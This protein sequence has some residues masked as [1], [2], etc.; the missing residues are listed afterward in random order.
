[1][2]HPLPTTPA[3]YLAQSPVITQIITCL[4][5][6]T[7][8]T[9]QIYLAP[10]A[11]WCNADYI[12][13]SVQQII[14]NE[15]RVILA[16]GSSVEYDILALNLGSRTR[17]TVGKD[18]VN[19]VWEHSLTTRPINLLLPKIVKKENELKKQGVIP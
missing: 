9:L 14:A 10:V 6:Y 15:N 5:L 3:C 8:Q 7:E 12:E 11:K 2:K 4:D 1:M 13:K 16:D 18:V 19:G 17:G